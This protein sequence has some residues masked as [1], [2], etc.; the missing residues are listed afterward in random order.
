MIHCIDSSLLCSSYSLCALVS[1]VC[2][3]YKDVMGAREGREAVSCP[4][5]CTVK[6]GDVAFR[7]GVEL[8]SFD[9]GKACGC[10]AESGKKEP[11]PWYKGGGQT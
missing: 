4:I 10:P 6:G 9:S 5:S 3:V 8:Q 1:P 7:G 2:L 11:W